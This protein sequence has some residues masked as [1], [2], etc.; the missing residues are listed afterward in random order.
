MDGKSFY[1]GKLDEKLWPAQAKSWANLIP[2]PK[3][4]GG[5]TDC[6]KS[7]TTF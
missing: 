2:N 6:Q 4:L 1:A 7:S 3:H 5:A